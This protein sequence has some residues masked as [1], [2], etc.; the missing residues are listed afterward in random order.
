MGRGAACGGAGDCGRARARQAETK[1]ELRA[2]L[3]NTE[4]ALQEAL[5]AL[6]LEHAALESAEKALEVERRAR[7]E[8]DREVLALRGPGDGDRGRECPAV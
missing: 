4:V 3:A 7:S 6:D 1:A 2:S 8:A 5:A